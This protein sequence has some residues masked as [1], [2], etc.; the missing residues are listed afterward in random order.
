[1]SAQGPGWLDESEH[2]E[3][4]GLAQAVSE[5][6]AAHPQAGPDDEP[7]PEEYDPG[8]EVDDEGGMSEYRHYAGW[9][10]V[11]RAEYEREASA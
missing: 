4:V 7:E 10:D 6:A 5:W 9:Q 8:P 2:D 1:M 11:D 3:P